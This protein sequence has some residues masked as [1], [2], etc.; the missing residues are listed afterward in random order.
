MDRNL[1]FLLLLTIGVPPPVRACNCGPLKPACAYLS[2]DAIFLGR[3]SS[4]NKNDLRSATLV[5][6]DVQE[7]FK[8]IAPAVHQIWVDPG[9]SLDCYQEYRFG[10]RYLIFAVSKHQSPNDTAAM[11]G[12]RDGEDGAEVPSTSLRS[13]EPLPHILRFTMRRLSPSRLPEH[14]PGLGDAACVS[15]WGSFAASNRARLSLSVLRLAPG[16]RPDVERRPSDHRQWHDD[17][18]SNDGRSRRLLTS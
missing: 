5:R 14:R 4:T 15:G 8:G 10:E 9:S 1:S 7:P 2:A 16:D 12:M 17:S 6:F 3:V 11:T 18:Q 13:Q